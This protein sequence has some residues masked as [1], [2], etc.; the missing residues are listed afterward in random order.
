MAPSPLRSVDPPCSRLVPAETPKL[1]ILV[2]AS[3]DAAAVTSALRWLPDGF[4]VPIALVFQR[5]AS[6]PDS[7]AAVLR[8]VTSLRII[9]LERSMPLAGATVYVAPADFHMVVEPD[10]RLGVADGGPVHGLA[11]SAWPLLATAAIELGSAVAALVLPGA[12]ADAREGVAALEQAG[13]IVLA[14]AAGDAASLRQSVD[15]LGA[16]AHHDKRER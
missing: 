7:L 6:V 5:P 12:R 13:A 4:E 2:A 11:S 8:R 1:I 10:G 3:G 16:L 15:V 14:P 9:A